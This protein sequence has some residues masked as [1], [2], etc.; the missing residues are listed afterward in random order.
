M[1]DPNLGIEL[2][3]GKGPRLFYIKVFLEPLQIWV[4]FNGLPELAF[5]CACHDAAP[6]MNAKLVKLEENRLFV[7]MEWC[8][9]HWGG[10][11]K[12]LAS[13]KKRRQMIFDELPMYKELIAKSNAEQQ[14]DEAT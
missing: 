12:I 14:A 10:D 1:S 13:L 7:D 3:L 9:S 8:I 6:I 5:L 4:D 2:E 11:K